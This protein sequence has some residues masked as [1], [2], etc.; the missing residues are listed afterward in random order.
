MLLLIASSTVHRS[1]VSVVALIRYKEGG[2]VPIRVSSNYGRSE[3]R[4]QLYDR[5]NDKESRVAG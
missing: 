4:E 2:C 1:L 5:A 3:I